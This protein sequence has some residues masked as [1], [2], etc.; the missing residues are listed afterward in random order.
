MKQSSTKRNSKKQKSEKKIPKEKDSEELILLM[1][2]LHSLR[3]E[4][5]DVMQNDAL[6]KGVLRGI[7][8][9]QNSS[10]SIEEFDAFIIKSV[11]KCF[12]KNC[13][14]SDII[15]MASGLMVGYSYIRTDIGKR[16]EDFLEKSDYLKIY[17]F[18]DKDTSDSKEITSYADLSNEQKNYCRNSKLRASEDKCF[19]TLAIFLLN[20]QNL[21]KYIKNNNDEDN[22]DD[23]EIV[24]RFVEETED[25]MKKGKRGEKVILPTPSYLR[26]DIINIEHASEII[27]NLNEAI[28]KIELIRNLIAAVFLVIFLFSPSMTEQDLYQ[29]SNDLVFSDYESNEYSSEI[30]SYEKSWKNEQVT[31]RGEQILGKVID[32]LEEYRL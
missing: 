10:I 1:A 13:I 16:R 7:G 26:N 25:Y 15:L 6:I 4:R 5:Q 17:P 8:Y 29:N 32:F 24:K 19:R 20:Q 27:E 31:L 21:K 3:N 23:T 9:A 30:P 11:D 28:R 2:Q 14:N 22:L 18:M 12:L